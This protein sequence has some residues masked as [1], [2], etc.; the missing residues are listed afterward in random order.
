[1]VLIEEPAMN[2]KDLNVKEYD[3]DYGVLVG[4]G[5]T[6]T[7]GQDQVIVD[8]FIPY[9]SFMRENRYAGAVILSRVL[10]PVITSPCLEPILESP[11]IPLLK[12]REV[13]VV[14]WE[15]QHPS[16]TAPIR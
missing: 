8:F 15:S 9:D 10:V 4:F 12:L 2:R 1:M 3:G 5:T 13:T 16:W 6:T 7:A 11:L 14:T